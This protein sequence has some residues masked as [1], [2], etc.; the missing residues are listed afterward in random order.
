MQE[1]KLF[2]GRKKWRPEIIVRPPQLR[3][4]AGFPFTVLH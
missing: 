2:S 3:H 4:A 1:K